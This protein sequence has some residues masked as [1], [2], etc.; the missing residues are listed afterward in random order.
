MKQMTSARG[1]D[2][3]PYKSVPANRMV[4]PQKN[5]IEQNKSI[6][7]SKYETLP[8]EEKILKLEQRK[9]HQTTSKKSVNSRSRSHHKV[10]NNFS[11]P[12]I[13]TAQTM[14]SSRKPTTTSPPNQQLG[15]ANGGC[16]NFI[17]C[18]SCDDQF[19]QKNYNLSDLN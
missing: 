10:K 8:L 11:L 6:L 4:T 1:I 5:F 17:D 9:A 16:S 15:D 18:D 14:A 3:T 12:R 19:D 2:A 7:K 13:D